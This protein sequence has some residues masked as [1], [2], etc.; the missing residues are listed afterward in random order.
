[1]KQTLFLLLGLLLCSPALA[2]MRATDLTPS[3]QQR[4]GQQREQ[5]TQQ[6]N[7]AGWNPVYVEHPSN[8][9]ATAPSPAPSQTDE[10]GKI[11]LVQGT[12]QRGPG[13]NYNDPRASSPYTSPGPYGGGTSPFAGT[14]SN[15]G[16]YSSSPYGDSSGFD[17]YANS[18]NGRRAS[19]SRFSGLTLQQATPP[20]HLGDLFNAGSSAL[21]FSVRVQAQTFFQE[22]STG[23]TTAQLSQGFTRAID[24]VNVTALD[25]VGD[26]VQINDSTTLQNSELFPIT[27]VL[28]KTNDQLASLSVVGAANTQTLANG[29]YSAA[30]PVTN[31]QI[32]QAGNNAIRREFSTSLGGKI[33]VEELVTLKYLED[34]STLQF[35]NGSLTNTSFVYQAS[36]NIPL[37]SP[38][39]AI[40]R[41]SIADNNSPMPRDR[42]FWD[43][44][45]FHNARLGSVGIPVNRWTP[46]FEKTFWGGNA[47]IELKAPF[48]LTLSSQ[49][50]T[51]GQDFVDIEFGNLALA[52]K[53]LL[54]RTEQYAWS[55][56]LGLQLPTA[57]D[58][59]L[60]L[61]DGTPVV[62]IKN[63]S[64]HV[65]PFTALYLI[66]TPNTFVQGFAQLDF[67][68][69]GNRVFIDEQAFLNQKGNGLA[70]AGRLADQ[71]TFRL[72]T[73]AGAYL[74]RRPCERFSA[75]SAV[76]ESHYTAS[77]GGANKAG[78]SNLS[79]G[80]TN[81]DLRL[82]N[83]TTGL[84][85]EFQQ[86]TVSA[87]YGFPISND[88]VFDGELRLLLNRYF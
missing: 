87:A 16:G 28:I 44:S 63:D 21:N 59:G 2:Q 66:P 15:P 38:G 64:V 43:Y 24:D 77:L 25:S 23:I 48:A 84:H 7:R 80:S 62:S 82:M 33:S 52:S 86:T 50:S 73:S 22:P 70:F 40:G 78:S 17:S 65:L 1:M 68:S 4:R 3:G 81:S 46:G 36:A 54:S 67:D 58:F 14:P 30:Q 75:L 34:Q 57:S 35:S 9:Q 39:Q 49:L 71:T 29:Q 41:Y 42:I 72:S 12:V 6:P 53:F 55:A 8:Y 18:L 5:L 45:F 47:S 61:A 69:N 79:I 13:L 60:T 10:S 88:R 51:D 32:Y 20:V 37:P 11:Q 83:I 74:M 56:G 27:S 85:A 76:V 26:L 19:P 31:A